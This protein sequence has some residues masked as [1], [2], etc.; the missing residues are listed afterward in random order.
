MVV[1]NGCEGSY[2]TG[3]STLYD[4]FQIP[5]KET[6]SAEYDDSVGC[7]V[8]HYTNHQLTGETYPN[9]YMF[10]TVTAQGS[11]K[12]GGQTILADDTGPASVSYEVTNYGLYAPSCPPTD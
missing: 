5:F 9:F 2:G 3:S 1:T 11:Y 6:D 8:C 7:V 12:Q 4:P 10:L